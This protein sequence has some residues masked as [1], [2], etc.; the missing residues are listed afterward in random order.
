MIKRGPHKILL[1][2]LLL[3]SFGVGFYL[4]N[5]SSFDQN[6]SFLSSSSVTA[7][8]KT[9]RV[10]HPFLASQ[11]PQGPLSKEEWQNQFH[12]LTEQMS[13][14]TDDPESIDQ[15]ISDFAQAMNVHQLKD[16]LTTIFSKQTNGDE[17][18]LATELLARSP[19]LE[20]IDYLKTV[21]TT[22]PNE[23]HGNPYLQ[24]E[25]RALQML[26]VE[27]IAQKFNHE[28]EAQRALEGLTRSVE[29]SHLL[30]RIHRSLWA[31]QGRAPSPEEQDREALQ[32]LLERAK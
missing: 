26:A 13:S 20:S 22:P 17:K 19:L 12:A 14:L 31:V 11:T 23:V 29:D 21:V 3:L 24:Q 7:G 28:T 27:G 18:L 8:S 9:N 4:F 2:I 30:D 1:I 15:Q 5:L 25:H 6:D 32:T 10:I 16:L